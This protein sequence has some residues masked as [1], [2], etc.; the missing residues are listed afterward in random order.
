[1]A[2]QARAALLRNE[3]YAVPRPSGPLCRPE[4]G[5]PSRPRDSSRLAMGVS[6]PRGR[7][8]DRRSAFQAVPAILLPRRCAVPRPAGPLCRPEVGVPSR[9]R[10]SSSSAMCG[11]AARR[12]ACRPEVGVPSRPRDSPSSAMCG[13]AARRAA[14]PTGGRRSKPSPRFFFLGDVRFRGPPGR[15]ADRRSAFQA[16]PAILLPRRCA[17]PRPSGPL[18]RPEVGVPSRPRDS[19]S[20]AMC[21]SAARR[22]AVPTG[23]RRSKPSPRFSFLGDVW[24]RGPPGRGADRRSA[25]QAVPAILLPQRCAVS[26]FRG[27]RC[28]IPL[29]PTSRPCSRRAL[30]RG[31]RCGSP[32]AGRRT[33]RA[34]GRVRPAASSGRLYGGSWA[35]PPGSSPTSR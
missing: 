23:G 29:T 18:C 19:S 25:F 11:S 26:W 21:G 13:S 12:A 31:S 32:S 15:G 17:V 14:V 6:R 28:V 1:M 16:V 3:P 7:G 2:P 10:D 34:A 22:A 27:L 5:V 9:P 30:R 24:F 35:F 33:R 20:S 8:A 4:V